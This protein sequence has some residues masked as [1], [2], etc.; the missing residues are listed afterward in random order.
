M[1]ARKLLRSNGLTLIGF[2]NIGHKDSHRGSIIDDMVEIS[3]QIQAA[4]C[5]DK[6]DA[7]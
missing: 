5:A 3:K 2:V 4:L 7:E 6:A 1:V